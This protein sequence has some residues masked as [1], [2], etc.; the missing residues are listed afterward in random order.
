MNEKDLL[1]KGY[2][3]YSG[4]SIDVFFNKDMC[5]HS[6]NCV[7]GLPKVFNTKKKPWIEPDAEPSSQVAS[8]IRNCPSNALQ[9]L[10]K[11][12]EI[13][14]FLSEDG[15]FYLNSDEG[16]TI[17][18]IIYKKLEDIIII[19]HTF[20]DSTLRGKD[21]AIKLVENIVRLAIDSDM[22]IRPLC[23]YAKSVFDKNPELDGVLHKL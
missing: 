14:N 12:D 18:E 4:K 23:P 17:A 7:R 19:E 6:G 3:I 16:K 11:E 13:I 8:T 9:Y 21:V 5:T 2:R 15:R 22:K 20:V 1:K 10:L